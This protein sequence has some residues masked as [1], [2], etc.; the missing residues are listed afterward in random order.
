MI[1]LSTLKLS[2]INISKKNKSKII[3][4]LN[5]LIFITFFALLSSS[6]SLFFENKIDTVEKKNTISEFNDLVFSNQIERTASNI[7][8]SENVLD[9]YYEFNSYLHILYTM[10]SNNLRL[11]N[12]RE[13]FYD[14]HFILQKRV[15]AN[16]QEM[17]RSLSDAMMIADEL[18]EIELIEKFYLRS[19]ELEKKFSKI[20]SDVSL[21]RSKKS[22]EENASR[23]EYNKFY[24]EYDN[25]NLR[26]AELLKEQINFFLSFNTKFFN[27][28]KRNS[29]TL[30]SKNLE[31]IKDYSKKE[32][33]FILFAFLIQVIIFLTVQ[34]FELSFEYQN[35]KSIKK[36]K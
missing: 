23:R 4:T 18:K 22:P 9:K 32:S 13:M 1:R 30:I 28:K 17:K 27:K 20:I 25:Y 36:I 31:T 35:R 6:I 34:V 3:N 19:M 2:F 16:E 29:E 7:K 21:Y 10:S 5:L 26:Y 11:F 15:K 8:F 24:K 12:E 14:I 33:Q